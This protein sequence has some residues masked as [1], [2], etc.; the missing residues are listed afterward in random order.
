MIRLANVSRTVTSGT[1]QLTI[2]HPLDVA[3]P[4]GQFIAITSKPMVRCA[5]SRLLIHKEDGLNNQGWACRT[6]CMMDAMRS[7][8]AFSLASCRRPA[9]VMA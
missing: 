7:Q 3:I 5:N 9:A 2:L 1:E 4:R 6:D 8:S